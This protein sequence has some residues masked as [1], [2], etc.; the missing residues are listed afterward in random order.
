MVD[1]GWRCPHDAPAHVNCV[2]C[3]RPG[4]ADVPVVILAGGRGARFDHESQVIPKPLIEVAGKPIMGHIM[5]LFEAQGFHQFWVLGGYLWE[6]LEEYLGTRYECSAAPPG[7]DD[8]RVFGQRGQRAVCHLF[9]SGVEA[10][11]GDRLM[12]LADELMLTRPVI[13]TYGDGLSDVDVRSLV[14]YHRHWDDGRPRMTVTAV[15]PPG[16]FG[17]LE[18]EDGRVKSFG[19]KPSEGWVNG[20]FM[21][22]DNGIVPGYVPRG[23]DD[24]GPY[25]SFE[26]GAMARIAATGRMNVWMHDGYWRCMDTRRDLE[27]I[28]ADV[29][30]AGRLPWL[31]SDVDSGTVAP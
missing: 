21:V 13:V 1:D 23:F 15:R 7:Y 5:D 17:V 9:N 11:T 29:R 24:N 2:D 12:R 14:E 6:R 10:S 25:E 16:R 22:I 27:Q 31:R 20:G 4:L 3:N 18:V 30:A 8:V 19:E 26:S 28:E